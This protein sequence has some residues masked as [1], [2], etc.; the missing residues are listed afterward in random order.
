MATGPDSSLWR[1]I[2]FPG[3]GGGGGRGGAGGGKAPL[4]GGGGGGSKSALPKSDPELA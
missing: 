4:G 1:R 3:A 2:Y